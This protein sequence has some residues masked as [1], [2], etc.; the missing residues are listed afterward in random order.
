MSHLCEENGQLSNSAVRP[1]LLHGL[2]ARLA[3]AKTRMPL[4]SWSRT[5]QETRKEASSMIIL[6]RDSCVLQIDDIDPSI[7]Q[8]QHSHPSS[9]PRQRCANYMVLYIQFYLASPLRA[10]FCQK[11]VTWPLTSLHGCERKKERKVP[12][13]GV[14]PISAS[15]DALV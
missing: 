15:V 2:L 8:N 6:Q 4:L 11:S 10:I 13:Q 5:S 7:Q 3:R 1:F 9:V 12:F 14:A